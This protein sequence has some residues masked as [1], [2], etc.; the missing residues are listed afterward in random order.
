ML[1]S[2]R[3]CVCV[4]VCVCVQ[5]ARVR[6]I[7]MGEEWS[8]NLFL[9]ILK[10]LVFVKISSPNIYVYICIYYIYYIYICMYIYIYIYTDIH[11]YI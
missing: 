6:Q 3:L 1:R 10:S 8:M 2:M 7:A 4:C 11:I 5:K 9:T